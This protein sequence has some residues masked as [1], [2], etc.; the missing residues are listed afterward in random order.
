[1]NKTSLP[2]RLMT[3]NPATNS[4]FSGEEVQ[5]MLDN[6]DKYTSDEVAEI[7]RMVDE[8]SARK[9]NTEAYNDL[10]EFCKRMQ[11]DYIVG[12]H[13]RM[14]GNMLMDIEQGGKDRICVNIPPRHGKSQL[15]SIFFPAWFLGR[16][17][18]K[19]VMMV[20]HTTDLAVDFGRKVRNL[21]IPIP[22]RMSLMGISKHLKKLM[23]GSLSGPE[24]D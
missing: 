7:D 1:M 23:S 18:N 17:P 3:D 14:L 8:L 9:Y 4:D 24:H 21:M 2:K 20:S 22:S 13:H 11:S 16:N 6:L 12:K 5:L 15:V 10:I 19:K